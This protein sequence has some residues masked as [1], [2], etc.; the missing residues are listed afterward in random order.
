V[1][2]S[3]DQ[4]TTTDTDTSS[5]DKNVFN[6]RFA[7]GR[8]KGTIEHL[9]NEA[10]GDVEL[11]RQALSD[12]FELD[13]QNM[14][15]HFQGRL[16]YA[17]HIIAR[18]DAAD[19][20]M[21]EYGLQT[22]KWSFLLNAGAIAVVLAYIGS[23]ANKSGGSIA[24]YTPIIREMWPFVAGCVA[25][26]LSGAAGY[27]NFCY[28]EAAMPSPEALNNFLA[29]TSTQW[30]LARVQLPEETPQEFNKRFGWWVSAS[31][32][33]AIGLAV[34]SAALFALGAVLIM[35]VILS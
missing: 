1:G 23:A 29:T 3:K 33:A 30:P 13:R 4:E 9:R 7:Q 28:F 32:N 2:A 19:K 6:Q 25:V 14:H 31:R 22:L 27:F 8:L 5:D 34:V 12:F 20:G 17:R 24:A 15:D 35:E 10:G 18:R 21:I 11:T 16:E 26:T